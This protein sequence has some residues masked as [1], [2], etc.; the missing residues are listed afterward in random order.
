[1]L[2]ES[3]KLERIPVDLEAVTSGL[4][5]HGD[6]NIEGALVDFAQAA[7]GDNIEKIAI[8][9]ANVVTQLGEDAMIDAAAVIANFQRM[10]R[11]ADG[12]GIPLDLPVAMITAGMRSRLGI[13]EF[14]SAANTP[15]TGFFKRLIGAILT[16]FLPVLFKEMSKRK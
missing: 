7:L 3:S 1:M 11:I 16:P 13:D 15:E 4:V 9:R 6:L 10:V 12:T 14:S 5:T 8:A 2:R